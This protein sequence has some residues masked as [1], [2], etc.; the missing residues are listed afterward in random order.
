LA[1]MGFSFG[2][3]RTNGAVSRRLDVTER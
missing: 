1:V 3:V 2:E